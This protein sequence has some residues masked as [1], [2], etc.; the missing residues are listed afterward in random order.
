[1]NS[2]LLKL[3]NKSIQR[4]CKLVPKKFLEFSY[5]QFTAGEL[6]FKRIDIWYAEIRWFVYDGWDYHQVTDTELLRKLEG[7]FSKL[8]EQADPNGSTANESRWTA[9]IER[10]NP[11]QN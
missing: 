9:M 4:P 10:L 2:I 6:R 7:T 5:S 3:C 1:M 8:V 11:Y